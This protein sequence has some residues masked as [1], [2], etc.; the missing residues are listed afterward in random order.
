MEW[1]LDSTNEV[2]RG[3]KKKTVVCLFFFF[4]LMLLCA[5]GTSPGGKDSTLPQQQ[6]KAPMESV[7]NYASLLPMETHSPTPVPEPVQTAM[8]KPT[9]KPSPT[10]APP[11]AIEDL[12]LDLK[13]IITDFKSE[14]DLR[15]SLFKTVWDMT[16]QLDWYV[17]PLVG[18]LGN[19]EI[20]FDVKTQSVAHAYF[21]FDY[22]ASGSK[23]ELKM[24][25]DEYT[26][27]IN[28]VICE[29]YP[30]IE[31]EFVC[32]CWKIPAISETSLY[33]AMFFYKSENGV[34]SRSE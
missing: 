24:A 15:D 19:P 18:E 3:T 25:A 4:F 29:M 2:P 33:S 1:N 8:P 7:G 10:P 14:L 31:L 28:A 32:Y 16:K 23:E 22:Y 26:E 5:C 12:G 30:S 6:K 17:V 27:L 11:S 13:P 21:Y 20:V 34:L 9:P